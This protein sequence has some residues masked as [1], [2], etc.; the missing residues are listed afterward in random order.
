DFVHVFI[1]AFLAVY[2]ALAPGHLE[3]PATKAW[4][5]SLRSDPPYNEL[6]RRMDL[7]LECVASAIFR[8]VPADAAEVFEDQYDSSGS[9]HEQ[10][11]RELAGAERVNGRS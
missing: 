11:Q 1:L 4:L 8:T 2:A 3:L 5:D 10:K 6:L 7:L 9:F